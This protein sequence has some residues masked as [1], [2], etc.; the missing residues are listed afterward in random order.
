M[1]IAAI[2][3]TYNDDYKFEEWYQYYSEYKQDLFL[4]IIVDNNSEKKYLS[5]VEDK[6]TDSIIIKRESNGGC[7]KAYNDGI[8]YAMNNS[9]VDA[10]MLVGNDLRFNEGMTQELYDLLNS[11]DDFGMVEPIILSKDSTII[12]DFG[13]DVSQSLKMVP[14]GLGLDVNNIKPEVRIVDAVA[15]G[16]NLATINFYKEVGLQDEVLFMYSDEIDMAIR[17]KEKGY[18]MAVS[19]SVRA[20]HNHINLPGKTKRPPYTAFLSGRNKIYLGYKHFGFTKAFYIFLSQLYTFIKRM[21]KSL[22]SIEKMKFQC[23]FLFGTFCGIIKCNKNFNFII[24]N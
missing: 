17:A 2:T 7:T 6:F 8:R 13:S 24:N 21:P 22:S 18:K 1:K 23:F 19:S 20:W 9:E 3:I 11:N 15:G 14:Y 16:M 10:I 12:E 5:K 4:H